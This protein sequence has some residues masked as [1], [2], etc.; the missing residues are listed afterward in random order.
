MTD[1]KTN[2]PTAN[3]SS[4]YKEVSSLRTLSSQELPSQPEDDT[5]EAFPLLRYFKWVGLLSILSLLIG[6]CTAAVT[7]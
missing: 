7:R 6:F 4:L 1:I 3:R 2:R 5:S